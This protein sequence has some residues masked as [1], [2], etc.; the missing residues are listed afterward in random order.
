VP[1]Y[2]RTAA[3]LRMYAALRRRSP[4]VT[5]AFWVAIAAL[6]EDL[7][8]EGFDPTAVRAT[9]RLHK[10]SG[11]D[12]WSISFAGQYRAVFRLGAQQRPGHAH[13]IWEFIGT[14][15]AYERAY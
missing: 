6:V 13:L 7:G 11:D 8:D 12:V 15:A 1:T 10:L 14:H 4:E 9:L 5:R 3:F 2:A